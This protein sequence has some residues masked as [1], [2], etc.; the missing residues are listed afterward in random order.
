MTGKVVGTSIFITHDEAEELKSCYE[1][2]V[3][4]MKV[5]MLRTGSVGN[6]AFDTFQTK[7]ERVLKKYGLPCDR[8]CGVSSETR[9]ILQVIET[10]P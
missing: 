1:G 7:L 9:E 5:N 6:D 8:S 2:A 10:S 3:L 4:V